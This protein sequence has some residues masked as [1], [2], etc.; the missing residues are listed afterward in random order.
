MKQKKFYETIL[1]V[2]GDNEFPV[3]MLRYSSCF[4]DSEASSRAIEESCNPMIGDKTRTVELR[5]RSVNPTLP[6]NEEARWNAYHWTVLSE[7]S[8][9]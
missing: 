6:A 9:R 2:Q 8:M 7:R 1:T 4:P 3:D 5:R